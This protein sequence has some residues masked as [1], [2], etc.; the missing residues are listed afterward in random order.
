MFTGLRIIG[1]VCDQNNTMSAAVNNLVYSNLK[2][3][4]QTGKKLPYEVDGNTIIHCFDPPHILKT[5][6][7]NLYTKNLKHYI[8]HVWVPNTKL[9]ENCTEEM[10]A[11][12]DDVRDFYEFNAKTT[13]RLIPKI[14][15]EHIDPKKLKM[16]VDVAAQVFSN[17][18]G[19][20]MM[21][22]SKKNILTRDFSGTAHILLFFNNVFDSMNGGVKYLDNCLRSC[23]NAKNKSFSF[24]F[25]EYSISMLQKM[26]FVDK[27]TGEVNNASSAL[28][29]C[30]STI[31]GY[32]QLVNICFSLGIDKISLRQM[33]QDGLENFFGQVRSVCHNQKAPIGY[34][35]QSGFTNLVV[36]GIT[37]KNSLKGNCQNDNG[38]PLLKDIN[39]IY[40]N[41]NTLDFDI[42]ASTS[43]NNSNETL[44]PIQVEENEIQFDETITD[45]DLNFCENEALVLASG[46]VCEKISRT[47]KCERCKHTLEAYKQLNDHGIISTFDNISESRLLT[48]P[49]LLFTSKFKVLFKLTEMLLPS[50]C[51]ERKVF[52]K[53]LSLLENVELD[54][55][56][57]NNHT[58]EI[59][60]KLKTLTIQICVQTFT[61]E[62]NAVLS[63]KTKELRSNPNEMLRKAFDIAKKK[64]GIGKCGQDPLK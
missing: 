54:G 21:F 57:C 51:H 16:R 30:I 58:S 7:N 12:W 53:L 5:V 46:K 15:S 4:K 3:V 44:E 33:N 20:I 24:Q 25:W 52:G 8:S 60:H 2:R 13:A 47:T 22:C 49:T 50:I 38:F 17:T 18:F 35:F 64:K 11:T 62:I 43:D 42:E 31:R 1:S 56:G 10:F 39:E 61:K 45:F 41:E 48:Y 29:K 26:T 28:Q 40:E 63:R 6:R 23:I 19:N 27:I 9:K 36:N 37:S 59:S 55:I 14:T 34:S 32:I